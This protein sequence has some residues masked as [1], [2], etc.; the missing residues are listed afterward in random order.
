MPPKVS[1][2]VP[3]YNV[4]KYL[5]R[6][7]RSLLSQ[8]LNDIEIIL[9]DDGSPDNCPR[10]CDEY[11]RHDTRVRVVHK[12]NGGLGMACNSGLE[13][14]T[15][16]YVAFCD[17]DDWVDCNMYQ[18]LYDT[19]TQTSA[20]IVYSGLK[21][22]DGDR[23]I[24][25]YLPHRTIKEIYNGSS[26]CDL[27]FDMIASRPEE[28]YDRTIQVSAKVALYNRRFL[29]R[30]HI[31]FVS[32]RTFPSEDLIFNIT[33][34]SKADTVVV[35]PDFFYNYFV[36]LTSIS[37]TVKPLHYAKIKETAKLIF[38]T[39]SGGKCADEPHFVEELKLRLARFL[40]GEARSQ[41][42]RI[43]KSDLPYREKKKLLN[44]LSD[45]MMSAA[46]INGY[47]ISRLPKKYA[48]I[49]SLITH[50]IHPILLFI[51]PKLL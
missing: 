1:I 2:V 50:R 9:V 11:A 35:V 34:L 16:E 13:V 31:K 49:H 24:I 5:D 44:G 36:N 23:N 12:K 18:S 8:S 26:V 43:I 17:S 32:E 21:R 15:G 46:F 48:A 40:I 45:D 7:M 3:V 4:E 22:A 42:A 41:C 27:I 19:A 10:L 6:C 14:A 25:G 47:P 30:E 29:N 39:L 20:D 38:S 37:T 28:K 33:A 51:L